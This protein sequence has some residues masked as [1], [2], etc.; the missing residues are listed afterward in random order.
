MGIPSR[1]LPP[2]TLTDSWLLA[3]VTE[4]GRSSTLQQF[5][6]DCDWLNRAVPT[7]DEAS[8][9]L[10]RLVAHGFI[11]I[12]GH[13]PSLRLT[14]TGPAKALRNGVAAQPVGVVAAM[15]NAMRPLFGASDDRSLGRVDG[16]T[17]SDWDRAVS[18]HARWVERW[19]RPLVGLARLLSRWQKGSGG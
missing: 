15:E 11:E 3:A 8:F 5:V 13:G 6:H 7:F 4:G 17:A 1:P 2:L 12:S 9:G 19:S 14:A 10:A 18:G 16:L